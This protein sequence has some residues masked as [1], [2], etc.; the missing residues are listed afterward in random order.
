MQR[1]FDLDTLSENRLWREKKLRKPIGMPR[2]APKE[3]KLWL[4]AN[5]NNKI[6]A[7]EPK[8][9]KNT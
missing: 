4:H 8:K 2:G 9:F 6:M 3:K 1:R 7:Y 5:R